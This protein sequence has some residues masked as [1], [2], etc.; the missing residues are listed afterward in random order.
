[1]LLQGCVDSQIAHLA[2]LDEQGKQVKEDLAALH[3]EDNRSLQRQRHT[4]A[5]AEEEVYCDFIAFTNI[6]SHPHHWSKAVA[7]HH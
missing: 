4:V 2:E 1:M 7:P 6:S 3:A 5:A